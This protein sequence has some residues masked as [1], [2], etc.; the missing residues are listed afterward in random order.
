MLT[1]EVPCGMTTTGRWD[2]MTVADSFLTGEA[3]APGMMSVISGFL[4]VRTSS[5]ETVCLIML[6]LSL[7]V[8]V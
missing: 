6:M 3:M 4:A 1:P 2:G 5:F 8:R 7:C